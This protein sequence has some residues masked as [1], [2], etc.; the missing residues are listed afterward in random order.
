M[1]DDV[2]MQYANNPIIKGNEVRQMLKAVLS[3]LDKMSLLVSTNR[4]LSGIL[5]KATTKAPTK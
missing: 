2:E 1:T 3:E 5:S 4:Q